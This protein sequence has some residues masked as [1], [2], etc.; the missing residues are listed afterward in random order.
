MCLHS[1]ASAE[2][3]RRVGIP[4]LRI[5][6]LALAVVL[7]LSSGAGFAAPAD[8]DY[9]AVQSTTELKIEQ[10]R[11]E[12]IR[13]VRTALGLRNPENRKADLY[14][15]LAELYLESYQANFQLEGRIHQKALQVD[16]NA[17]LERVRSR[18]D[19]R[20][21][22]SAAEALLSLRVPQEK[23]DRVHY[24]LGY[25][26][27]EFGD[28]EKS[29]RHYEILL[30]DFPSSGFAQDA[31]RALGDVAFQ[32]G[33]FAVAVKNYELAV[34]RTKDPAQQARL[35]H[36]L[37]WC[38]Y[39]ERRAE[40]AVS[41]MKR[42]IA[43]ARAS[44]ENGKLLSIRDEGLR[45]LAVY[46]AETGRVDEAIEYFRGNAGKQDGVSRVLEKLGKEFERTGRVDEAKRV[47]EV[48]FQIDPESEASFRVAVKMIDLEILREKFR[49][50][51]TRIE[52]LFIPDSRDAETVQAVANLRRQIRTTAVSN[53]ERY[54]KKTDRKEARPFLEVADRFYSLFLMKFPASDEAARAGINEIRMYLAEVK[55]EKGDSRAAADLYQKVIRDR[56][57]KHAIEAARLW[58][59]SLASEL[60]KRSARGEKPGA[61]PSRLELD[62]VEASDLLEKSIPASLESRE[63]R[64]RS[65]QILAAYPD[66]RPEAIARAKALS[67]SAPGTPQGVLAARLWL[68]LEKTES[69]IG[70][71]SGDARLM[72]ADRAARGELARDLEAARKSLRVGEISKL[73][74]QKEFGKAA[75]AY[76]SYARSAPGEKEAES[77]YIGALGA[78]A[79]N[80]DSDEVLRVMREWRNRFPA[81]RLLEKSV[82]EEATRCFIRGQFQD[83]A[84]LFLGLGRMILDRASFMTA[85]ALFSGG[86]QLRKADAVFREALSAS[87]TAAQRAEIFKA[88]A[89]NAIE[90]RNDSSVLVHWKECAALDSPLRAECFCQIGN[91]HAAR[92][93]FGPARENFD[94]AVSIRSGPSAK[95]PHIAYAQFRIAQLL[96]RERKNPALEFPEQKIL[97]AFEERIN[98][99]K[100]VTAAY[101]KAIG[102]GGPWAIAATERLGDLSQE[103]S[104]DVA[105]VLRDSRATPQLRAALLPASA[106]LSKQATEHA[107]SAYQTALR[108]EVLS[109][110]LPVI[111]DRLVDAGVPGLRRAQGARSGVKLIGMA[112]D[113]GPAGPENAFLRVREELLKSQDNAL[114]WIDYGNL[115]WGLGK[116]GLAR[117]AYERSLALRT[118]AADAGNNLAVVLISDLGFEDWFAANEAVALW[119]KALDIEPVNSAALFNLGHVFNYYR[120]FRLSI[121][122]FKK[123]SRRV[124]IGEVF[125]GLSVAYWGLGKKSEAL[126]NSKRAEELGLSAN[127]FSKKYREAAL[128][129]GPSCLSRIEGIP[130]LSELKG[131]EKISIHRLKERCQP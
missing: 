80:R 102:F 25:N 111:Q 109:S 68:Q 115:L 27:A 40:L 7:A 77:A 26:Y 54:R 131:F 63:A 104:Q 59:G 118:R 45:D 48:L 2:G 1:K 69:V 15:R 28:F 130:G 3:R 95:S 52:R 49:E 6:P 11:Q 125:D 114:A 29:R 103:F 24:F 75:A 126:V 89:L 16:P 21:G 123:V 82:K 97:K 81:S 108:E 85:A 35:L 113:G 101:Q 117:I 73:E 88:L 129:E 50:A 128:Y 43:I 14:L 74:R 5:A 106:A 41:T 121:P 55:R 124:K 105:R 20:N 78:H 86:S 127:R 61:E 51:A 57:P 44:D 66:R 71:I 18:E 93:E 23:R 46:Y 87:R 120:L 37:A 70:A 79:Q 12:E 19:L 116:P 8:R 94:S 47:Y 112:P 99:L 92:Q 13:A 98:E 31:L 34:R 4:E 17:R 110:A 38:Y 90:E 60:E 100:P 91:F 67:R 76:E 119:K 58:V 83:S 9:R 62:F 39:R 36:K 32:S 56:D 64:L 122:Y 107:K 72:A 42:A 33:D 22:V 10:L 30:R 65:A 96:E 84:E 53:H